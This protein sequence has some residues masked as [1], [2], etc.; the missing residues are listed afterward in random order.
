MQHSRIHP[1]LAEALAARGYDTLTSVQSAVIEDEADG[2]DLIVSAKTG[3]GKTVAFGLAIADQ[4]L[5][6]DRAP[7]TR[8]PLGLVI[9]PTRELAIQVSKELE[10]LY[11]CGGARVVTCVGGMD[12]MKER[13]A[14]QGGAHI[15]VGTP[16]RLRDHLERGALDLSALRVAVL[17]EADEMLDM[18]FREE[19]EEILD[20]TPGET[21]NLAVLRHHARARSSRWP[22]GTRRTRCGSRRSASAR[23]MPTSPTRRSRSPRPTSS[24]SW[25]TF[26]GCTKPRRR[27]CSARPARRCGACM[28]A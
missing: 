18:G 25:S 4:L 12:P 5:E 20:A 21:A 11:A 10:W 16:G 7:W 2:R 24:M 9:A 23:L 27:S 14:L 6:G 8:E 15:V 3:S 26:S 13:R 1:A 28:P 17:D 22:A 19:L